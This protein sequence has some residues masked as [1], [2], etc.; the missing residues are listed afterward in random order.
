VGVSTREERKGTRL[1]SAH[2]FDAARMR[3]AL[4]G[5]LHRQVGQRRPKSSECGF[6]SGLMTGRG[7]EYD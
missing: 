1:W 3:T 4:L 5:V 2:R 6:S 7:I